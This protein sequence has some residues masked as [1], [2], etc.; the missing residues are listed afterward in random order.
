MGVLLCLSRDF[1][2]IDDCQDIKGFVVFGTSAAEALS[3]LRMPANPIE[4]TVFLSYRCE[5]SWL[6]TTVCAGL[7][8]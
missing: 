4:R 8:G 1:L 3:S 6:Y 2:Q 5:A 7:A